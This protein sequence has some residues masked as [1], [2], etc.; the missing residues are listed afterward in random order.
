LNIRGTADPGHESRQQETLQLHPA[1]AHRERASV[2]LVVANPDQ[3]AAD[4]SPT[5]VVREQHHQREERKHKGVVRLPGVEGA[6]EHGEL[7]RV[8]TAFSQRPR[9]P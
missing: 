9:L 6:P 2:V 1:S 7:A 3:S 8:P 4:A 5:H